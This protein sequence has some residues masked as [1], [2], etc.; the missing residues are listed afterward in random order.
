MAELEYD[1]VIPDDGK[2]Y[3]T[4]RLFFTVRNYHLFIYPK[5][6]I[7][8]EVVSSEQYMVNSQDYFSRAFKRLE[9][10]E[11]Y[12]NPYSHTSTTLNNYIRDPDL[13]PKPQSNIKK[14]MLE[15]YSL[16]QDLQQKLQVIQVANGW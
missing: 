10:V 6:K 9:F 2:L 5:F 12:R 3:E 4:K 16:H 7:N 8:G 1:G 11:L 14:I 13:F 15:E